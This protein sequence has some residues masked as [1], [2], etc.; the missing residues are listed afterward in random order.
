MLWQKGRWSEERPKPVQVVDTI[1]AGDAFSAAL[2]I[3]LLRGVD[4]DA[5]H[6]AA[7]EVARFVCARAGATPPMPAELR[8]ILDRS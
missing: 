3:G 2:A 1:G 7:A 6:T 5:V 8:A 4:L